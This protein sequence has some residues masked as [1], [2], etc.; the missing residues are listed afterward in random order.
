LVEGVRGAGLLLG[1]GLTAP[2]AAAVA[3]ALTQAGFLANAVQPGVLRLAPPLI[4][5]TEQADAFVAA[6]PAALDA[7]S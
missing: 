4:L 5:T 2:V 7:A 1:V 3:A 6:L